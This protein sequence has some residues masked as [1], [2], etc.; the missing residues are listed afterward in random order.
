MMQ[1]SLLVVQRW[2]EG[3]DRYRPAGEVIQTA[4]YDVA[5]LEAD[6]SPKAFVRQ[7]HY[8]GTYPAARFRFGLFRRRIAENMGP[9][10]RFQPLREF[11]ADVAIVIV[12][13][14]G[15]EFEGRGHF[16]DRHLFAQSP[17][18]DAEIVA[19]SLT[20]VIGGQV[21]QAFFQQVFGPGGQE[22]D[23]L[24]VRHGTQIELNLRQ[25]L[26]EA[27]AVLTGAA[28]NQRSRCAP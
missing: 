14:A 23:F 18:E 22:G 12:D 17:K 25:L 6:A 16:R 5:V 13:V 7:H 4:D 1:P 21:V 19:F 28:G 27:E 8:S 20:V 11:L 15:L 9:H 26:A 2:R 10:G 3:R 24:L